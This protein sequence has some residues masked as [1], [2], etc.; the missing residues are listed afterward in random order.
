MSEKRSEHFSIKVP[1]QSNLSSKIDLDRLTLDTAA[2]EGVP[3]GISI[4]E[5]KA[6]ERIRSLDPTLRGLEKLSIEGGSS[7]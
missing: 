3:H 1:E 7:C 5:W 6:I 2:A 4:E